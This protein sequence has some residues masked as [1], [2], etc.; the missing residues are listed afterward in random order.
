[1]FSLACKYIFSY[2]IN[3]ID[4]AA[5]LV[6]VTLGTLGYI[7]FKYKKGSQFLEINESK[8]VIGNKGVVAEIKNKDFQGYKI[9]KFLPCQVII[10]NKIYGKTAFSYYALSLSQRK[11]IFELLEEYSANKS[12]KQDS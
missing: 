6:V 5:M 2:S 4:H 8:I 1:M 7:Q 11:K 10:K 9:S 12:L 3:L